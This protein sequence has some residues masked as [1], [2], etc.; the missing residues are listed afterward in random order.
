MPPVG[1]ARG[2]SISQYS[3]SVA[4]ERVRS[5]TFARASGVSALR[6]VK[7]AKAAEL[8]P[9]AAPAPAAQGLDGVP[10]RY[11]GVDTDHG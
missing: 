10:S 11:L 5:S 1:E 3:T 9:L 6:Y 4:E 7:G 8:P 2:S